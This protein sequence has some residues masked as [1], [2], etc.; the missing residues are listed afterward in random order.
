MGWQHIRNAVS[1]AMLCTVLWVCCRYPMETTIRHSIRNTTQIVH[2]IKLR[3]RLATLLSVA[4]DSPNISNTSSHTL[5]EVV[6]T[7]DVKMTCQRFI[8]SII[9]TNNHARPEVQALHTAIW[10]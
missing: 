10:L 1:N 2:G 8:Y 7:Y 4:C 5:H 6:Q 3:R 9:V